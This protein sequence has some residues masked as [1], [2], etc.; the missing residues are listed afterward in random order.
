M[1]VV[2]SAI[3]FALVITAGYAV[4]TRLP[5]V[6]VYKA[7]Y[8]TG[9]SIINEENAI[10][11][12]AWVTDE[13]ICTEHK[14]KLL[15]SLACFKDAETKQPLSQIEKSVIYQAAQSLAKGT[16]TIDEIIAD[17][18]KRCTYRKT[19]LFFDPQTNSWF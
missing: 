14:E 5:W 4:T 7:C 18:N 19:T 11:R 3:L 2:L 10:T 1:R 12:R 13:V 16:Q 17:H 15:A 9:A 6:N 8:E